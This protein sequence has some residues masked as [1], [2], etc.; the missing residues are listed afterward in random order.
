MQAKK[1]SA[2]LILA[3]VST[4]IM[5]P[6]TLSQSIF[7]KVT[8]TTEQ[9]AYHYR[10]L[11]RI[12]G[13]VT[14]EDALVEEGLVGL[15]VQAPNDRI[16][17]LRTVP[18][19]A[20]PSDPWTIEITSFMSTDSNGNPKDTFEKDSWAW[21]KVSIRNNNSFGN[22]TVLLTITLCDVDSTPFQLHW[23]ATVINAQATL[24]EMV[25]LLVGAY[26]GGDWVST[27]G[28]TAYA[29]V[30]TD[31]PLNDGYPYSPEKS[32]NFTITSGSGLSSLSTNSATQADEN[33][34]NSYEA[35]IRLPPRTPLGTCTIIAS[36]YYNGH[37]D[38]FNTTTFDREYEML[39]DIIFNHKIDIYDIVAVASAYATQGGSP[40]WN[41][42]ADVTSA[43]NPEHA[44]GKV[45]LY[46]V[47]LVSGKYGTTY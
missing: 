40:L 22:N 41:P 38:A 46:D 33:G 27:G 2:C 26:D 42:E 31:W 25:R 43:N 12:Y 21:F 35:A 29:N 18:A 23:L 17:A 39:G 19:N 47:V 15:Q 16:I 11:V 24:T 7:L 13:N 6:T 9:S 37:K 45:N 8:V 32:A 5:A 20:T 4:L 1:V 36:A 10:Q 44:D 3:L 30:Y 14:Y 28:A 34:Y